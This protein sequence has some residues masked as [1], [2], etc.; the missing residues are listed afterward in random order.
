MQLVL[1][2]N[3][4]CHLSTRLPTSKALPD[5]SDAYTSAIHYYA[6]SNYQLTGPFVV[7]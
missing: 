6:G 1:H 7:S 3:P 5:R 4:T 2:V